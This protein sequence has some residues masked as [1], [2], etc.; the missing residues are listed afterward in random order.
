MKTKIAFTILSLSLFT[1]YA[2][3]R[4]L[5]ESNIGVVVSF[6]EI[7][8]TTPMVVDSNIFGKPGANRGAYEIFIGDGVLGSDA[9]HAF[10]GRFYFDGHGVH[11]VRLA[12]GGGDIPFKIAADG[13][14][15]KHAFRQFNRELEIGLSRNAHGDL[16]ASLVVTTDKGRD[17]VT[18]D[19]DI[20]V[21]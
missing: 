5:C 13:T 15:P 16:E 3:A 4:P 7:A 12:Q 9:G 8:C 6:P 2:E 19:C 11:Y 18:L 14:M 1:G 17:E 10:D 20:C 21:E